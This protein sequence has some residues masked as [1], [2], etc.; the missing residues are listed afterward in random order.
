M[1]IYG[2]ILFN[3]FDIKIKDS[4]YLINSKNRWVDVFN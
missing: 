4:E 1:D 2:K 3:T